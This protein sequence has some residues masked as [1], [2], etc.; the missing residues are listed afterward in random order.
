MMPFSVLRPW[1]LGI[2]SWLLLG[3]EIYCGWRAIEELRREPQ[4]VVVPVEDER[5]ASEINDPGNEAASEATS[6]ATKIVSV[7]PQG[8]NW[9]LWGYLAA[10]VGFLG[11]NFGGFIPIRWLLSTPS[12]PDSDWVM[13]EKQLWVDRPDGSR[14]HV[15]IYGLAS[16]PTLLLTHGWSLDTS[17]WHYVIGQLA[18]NTRVVAWDLPGLGR[19]RGPTNRDWSLEKM[20][21]DLNAVLEATATSA[22]VVLA[23]HSIGGMITQVFCRLYKKKLGSQV[24][25]LALLH[26]TYVNPLRTCFAAPLATALELPL[27]TPLNYLNMVLAPLVWLSNW[28]SYLNGSLHVC[29]R[30]TTFS[31]EQSWKQL[32]HA[33]RL[34]AIAWPGV[35]AR[36]NLAMQRF[37]EEST[38]FEI[39][40]PVLVLSGKHDRMTVPAASV[41]MEELLPA[42][43]P[44]QVSSGHLGM[45][46]CPKEFVAAVTE[47]VEQC[48]A[49]GKAVNAPPET[50]RFK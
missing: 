39:D 9:P 46:E 18:K 20:A 29:T 31:G 38:L 10:T 16:G 15:K 48:S 49:Q 28:Q 41:H 5:P 17:A 21:H 22:P 44:F 30:I 32:D 3:L 8:I 24:Q 23:G 27:I 26:T 11:V 45:W 35:L 19:S 13:P 37:H 2:F 42:D 33:A 50:I 40:V 1:G 47:F 14:L 43:R 34:A 6:K 7:P 4:T 12:G 36:G 25:G